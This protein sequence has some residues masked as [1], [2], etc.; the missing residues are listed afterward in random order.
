[1]P[2]KEEGLFLSALLVLF[3]MEEFDFEVKPLGVMY[4]RV[5]FAVGLLMFIFL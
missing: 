4:L 2:I 5:E 3:M 1:M